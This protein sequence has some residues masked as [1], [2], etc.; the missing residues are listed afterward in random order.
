MKLP[1]VTLIV[2]L[3]F[4]SSARAQKTKGELRLY[5]RATQIG[6]VANREFKDDKGRV[7]KV[8][9]YTQS[10]KSIGSARS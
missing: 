1:P 8:I 5:E 6:T 3:L 9:Y 2:V 10:D 4:A 7:V